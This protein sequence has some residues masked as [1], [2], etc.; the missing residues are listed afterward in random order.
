[1]KWK[2]VTLLVVLSC[3]LLAQTDYVILENG[4]RISGHIK[5]I[6]LPVNG[7]LQLELWRDKNDLMP[8]KIDR[9]NTL[10]Y[11]IGKDKYK[12]FVNY[13][14]FQNSQFYY[15]LVEAKVLQ[16]GPIDLLQIVNNA[17]RI[18]MYVGSVI[19]GRLDSSIGNLSYL[20]LL[21]N[22]STDYPMVI[23]SRKKFFQQGLQFFF[24]E[25]IREEFI[26]ENNDIRYSDLENLIKL[27][28]SKAR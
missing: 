25:D 2:G 23:T 16:T 7:Q 13:Y 1:M 20:Y 4:S 24:P 15:E 10:E 26:R 5:Y 14:P 12:I 28:N 18:N 11:G 22:H 17:N 9:K 3:E 21:D 27:Y 19:K 8:L 6:T